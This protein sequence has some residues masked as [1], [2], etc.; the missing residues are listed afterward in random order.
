MAVDIIARALARQAKDIIITESDRVL[1]ENERQKAEKAREDA[2]KKAIDE[3][4]KATSAASDVAST[5]NLVP[6]SWEDVQTIVR[7]GFAKSVFTVGDQFVCNKDSSTLVWDIIGID[8]DTP[9]DTQY[10]HSLTLQLHDVFDVMMYDNTE[11]LYYC[12][13]ELAAGT[14]NFTLLSGYDTAYGGGKTWQFTT[15][16]AVPAGGQITFAW[17]YNTQVSATKIRTYSNRTSTTALETLSVTEGNSGTSLGTADGKTANMNHTHRLRF[18]SNNWKESSL[19]QWLNSSKAAGSVWTPQTVFDR[20][21]N[22]VTTKSGWMNGIDQD[23]LDVIGETKKVTCR[24]TVNE[25]GTSD[26]TND[27]FFLLSRREVFGGDERSAIKEEEPYP[28]YA[29]HSDLATAGTGTD[30]NRIK[31]QKGTARWYW[32]RSPNA[33]SAG[34]VRGV[35]ASGTMRTGYAYYNVGVAPACNII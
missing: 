24:N 13:T 32:L 6:T 16:K 27:K 26:T 5:V 18:G 2:T 8:I 22:W 1:N 29:N 28:Y 21:P 3:C 10:T 33:D 11:A 30:R 17:G 9:T 4:E 31:Y 7:K 34:N 35:G 19:R 23:F 20:P 15:T 25:D 14:Y 12:A